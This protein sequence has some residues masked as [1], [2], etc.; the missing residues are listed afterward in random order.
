MRKLYFRNVTLLLVLPRD[1]I[2]LK[3]AHQLQSNTAI[4]HD[5]ATPPAP[6]SQPA[7]NG[8]HLFD[9]IFLQQ[10]NNAESDLVT[11]D[12]VFPRRA[13]RPPEHPW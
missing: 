6:P 3:H 2:N 8:G 4:S 10:S 11:K 13:S 12:D 1:R 7:E 5:E 9:T